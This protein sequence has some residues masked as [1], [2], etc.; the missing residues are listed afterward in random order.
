MMF[1]IGWK[2][3]A[4]L[5]LNK[6]E[7]KIASRIAKKVDELKQDPFSKDVKH[8]K[9]HRG[10]RLRVGDYRII[11]EVERGDEIIIL[12]VGHRKHIYDRL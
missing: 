9:S 8:L 10:F 1:E 4:L 6:L 2:E 12:K 11:F 3:H 5:D 7:P